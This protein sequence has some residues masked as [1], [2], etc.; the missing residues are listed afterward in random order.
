VELP[1]TELEARYRELSLKLHP[2]RF[3]QAPAQERRY[4]LERSTALN[5]A[6]KTLKDPI[7]RVFYLLKL[8]GL[9]LDREDAGTQKDIPLDFLEEVMTLREQLDGLRA[10]KDLAQARKMAQ[11]VEQRRDAALKAA[12]RAL[13]QRLANPLDEASLR[14]AS[15]AAAR[16]RYFTRFLEKVEAMEEEAIG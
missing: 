12:Q 8:Q 5:Q 9:D 13:T 7:R 10:K 15:F 1:V 14:Q 3:A 16:V 4:S 2:D 11:D 6:Y